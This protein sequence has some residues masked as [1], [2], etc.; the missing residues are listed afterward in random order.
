ME[1]PYQVLNLWDKSKNL[2]LSTDWHQTWFSWE[3]VLRYQNLRS[4][5]VANFINS[6]LLYMEKPH[7]LPHLGDK[8]QNLKLFSRDINYYYIIFLEVYSELKILTQRVGKTSSYRKIYR[9][10]P[11]S[12]KNR[13]NSWNGRSLIHWLP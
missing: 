4:I 3:R 6:N 8:F 7:Q 11:T 10:L 12:A 9:R 1:K 13:S 2:K 5:T